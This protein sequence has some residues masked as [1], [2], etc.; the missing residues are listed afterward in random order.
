MSE[1]QVTRLMAEFLS[2]NGISMAS[3][4]GP[5]AA[6]AA[7][8]M[9]DYVQTRLRHE[10]SYGSL[11]EAFERAPDETAEEM[12]GTLEAMVEA[13]GEFAMRLNGFL[14][15][16]N[17]A[18][19]PSDVQRMRRAQATA[20]GEGVVPGSGSTI[21]QADSTFQA[22]D[23]DV[24]REGMYLYGGDTT[25][26]RASPELTGNLAAIEGDSDRSDGPLVSDEPQEDGAPGQMDSVAR[27]DIATFEALYAVIESHPDLEFDTK[28]E[29]QG[30]LEDIQ[31]RLLAASGRTRESGSR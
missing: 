10:S 18:V 6:T 11:W 19:A 28:A 25:S 12:E 1:S 9:V 16:Y 7:Q 5:Q 20:G 2:D 15:E 8:D 30:R 22:E 13:D 27:R 3:R 26:R 14:E 29:L 17:L 23:E 4:D 31:R 24:E 21:P